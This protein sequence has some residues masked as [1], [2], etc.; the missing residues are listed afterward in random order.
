MEHYRKSWKDQLDAVRGQMEDTLTENTQ[1]Q[2][3]AI[4]I[5]K[6]VDC[7]LYTSDAADE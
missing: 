1:K 3:D 5:D 6:L 7:L 4:E 2:D